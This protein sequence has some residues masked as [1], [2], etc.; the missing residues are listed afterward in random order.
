MAM[1]LVLAPTGGGGLRLTLSLTSSLKAGGPSR[2]GAMSFRYRPALDGLR[3]LAV[4]AVLAFHFPVPYMD[5]GFLGVDLFFVLSGFLITTLLY[6]EWEETGAIRLG[7]FYGRR[8]LRLFPALAVCLLVGLLA[9]HLVGDADLEERSQTGALS[10]ALYTANWVRVTRGSDALGVFNHTWSLSMEEQFYIV[11]PVTLWILLRSGRTSRQIAGIL[12]LALALSIAWRFMLWHEGASFA[13]LYNGSDTHADPL[14]LGCLLAIWRRKHSACPTTQIV[15]VAAGALCAAVLLARADASYMFLGV[16]TL[17]AVACAV[18]IAAVDQVGSAGRLVWL[19]SLPPLVIIGRL[20]YSLYLWHYP[21]DYLM[22]R[23]VLSKEWQL[24]LDIAL[25]FL[26]AFLSYTYVE[27][28]F[29]RL[30]RHLQ[31]VKVRPIL[32]REGG[33]ISGRTAT[34]VR[35]RL[36][37]ESG[38]R[39]PVPECVVAREEHDGSQ[40]LLPDKDRGGGNRSS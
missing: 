27:R 36:P 16:L 34:R 20:S 8:A 35:P 30:K 10:A 39:R 31:P 13:R 5:G 15:A 33:Q 11:W 7:A 40:R 9:V 18:L 28:P 29:L 32:A 37:Q 22:R 19:L 1:C 6:V 21:V 2:V 26:L 3:A 23:T 25:S 4:L 12:T 38:L 14:L 24:P 17:L